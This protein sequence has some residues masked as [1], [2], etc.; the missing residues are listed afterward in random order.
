MFGC[1]NQ[2]T[3]R[4]QV[5]WIAL[6]KQFLLKRHQFLQS[7]LA[8]LSVNDGLHNLTHN[9]IFKL[10][11]TREMKVSTSTVATLF[12]KMALTRQRIATVDMVLL[13]LPAFPYIPE[14]WM[15]PEFPFEDFLSLLSGWQ[16]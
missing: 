2:A 1:T 14:G 16:W 10:R 5:T 15:E 8:S 12:S 6:A 9:H 4:R 13:V 3:K 11:F 7:V